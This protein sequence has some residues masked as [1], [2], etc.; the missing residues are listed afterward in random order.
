[1]KGPLWTALAPTFLAAA[2]QLMAASC[3]DAHPSLLPPSML[4]QLCRKVSE[5]WFALILTLL[6][7]LPFDLAD[8]V[9]GL[10]LMVGLRITAYPW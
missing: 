5:A 1:M 8:L 2:V 4:L 3:L 9:Q 6:G 7:R 10:Q